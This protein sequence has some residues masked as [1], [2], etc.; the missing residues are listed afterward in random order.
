MPTRIRKPTLSEL[1]K[2][3]LSEAG[4]RMDMVPHSFSE[5]T[6]GY[7]RYLVTGHMETDMQSVHLRRHRLIKEM[8]R[9]ASE[10][11]RVNRILYKLSADAAEK[12]FSVNVE[13]GPGKRARIEAQG[14]LER[15]RYL[16]N[17]REYLRGWI[18]A[19]LRDG[20]LF[21]Q[22]MV[23]PE[24]EIVKAK[25][26][27]TEITFSRKDAKG[28]FPK[29]R[30]PYYQAR[31]FFDYE[32]IGEFEEWE[33]VHAKWRYEDGSPYGVPLFLAGQK[34]VKR[35][36]SGEENMSIRRRL[37][38]G[39]RF[40]YNIGTANNP[41]SWDEVRK[42]KEL[43]KDT[44]ENPDNVVA[45]IYGNGLMD[46]KAIQ[47]DSDLGNK[48]DIDHFE[49][50]ISMVGL[51]PSALMS[52]G[53]EAATNMNVIDAEEDDYGRTLMAICETAE[54][55]FVRP[56]LDN[57]LLFSGINPDSIDYSINWGAD[58]RESGFR[59]L[60]KA[61]LWSRLGFS[62]ETA[63]GIADLDTGLSF[64]DELARI[65][66]QMDREIIPYA[67]PNLSRTFLDA[68]GNSGENVS[69]LKEV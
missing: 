33:I 2:V 17:D 54:L 43:N 18:E 20:D 34:A 37:R 14:V 15:C 67:G 52:G 22:L 27:A 36:D 45:N 55:G 8:R 46:M 29:D 57:S 41:S 50:L 10:D 3:P 12:S 21:L 23:S 47:G 62:H 40:F 32:L 35:V 30:K 44:L 49:G 59:K 68:S 26:L 60:Q 1:A 31:S 64:E 7:Q 25:K 4:G 38:A 69:Q 51:V 53:R 19:L 24:R 16:I 5:Q 6:P 66:E 28:D 39:L 56:I 65:E 63:Y 11:A 61:V 58:G 13:D 48:E 9:M 42:F